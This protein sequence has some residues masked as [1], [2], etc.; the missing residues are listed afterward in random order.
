MGNGSKPSFIVSKWRESSEC[1]MYWM[2][3]EVWPSVTLGFKQDLKR[4]TR[5]EHLIKA[6][7]S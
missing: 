5:D 6:M 1:G 3:S 4:E 2:C 7:M